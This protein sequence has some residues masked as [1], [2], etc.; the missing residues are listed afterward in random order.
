[1]DMKNDVQARPAVGYL[2]KARGLSARLTPL[3]FTVVKLLAKKQWINLPDRFNPLAV[4]FRMCPKN[5]TL[6]L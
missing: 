4:A 3:F 1:M 5:D 2:D 6:I